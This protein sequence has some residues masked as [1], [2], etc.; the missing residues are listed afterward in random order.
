MS[1][2]LTQDL[3]GNRLQLQVGRALVDLPDLGVAEQLLDRMLLDE[4]VAAEQVHRERRDAFGNFRRKI[5]QMAASVRNGR[6]ASRSR[7]AL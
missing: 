7:A 1:D 5:L 4:A 2:R 3:L 6:R